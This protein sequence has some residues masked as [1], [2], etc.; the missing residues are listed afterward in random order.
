[1]LPPNF[2]L[3][4]KIIMEMLEPIDIAARF[5]DEP[6]VDKVDA[7]VRSVMQTALAALSGEASMPPT[8][9]NKVPSGDL[10]HSRTVCS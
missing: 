6:D 10:P 2:P 1:V 9:E 8:R 4:A 7:H 3:P 5:G